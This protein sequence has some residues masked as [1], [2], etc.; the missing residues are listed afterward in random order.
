MKTFYAFLSHAAISV[1]QV[2]VAV[3]FFNNHTS[4]G[5]VGNTLI[6][7][8]AQAGLVALQGVIT[9]TNSNTDPKGVPLTKLVDGTYRSKSVGQ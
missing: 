9:V 2:I 6:Q 5:T 4:T 8:L 1:L 7:I 3:P